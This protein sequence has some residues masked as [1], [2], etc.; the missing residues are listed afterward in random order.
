[1]ISF[2]DKRFSLLQTLLALVVVLLGTY[3]L[4]SLWKTKQYEAQM[5]STAISCNYDIKRLGGYQFVKPLMFVDE[6]CESESLMDTKQKLISIIDQYKSTGAIENASVYLREYNHNEW[7]TINEAEKFDPGSLFKVPIMITILK[8]NELNPGFLNKTVAYTHAFETGK[9]VEFPSKTITVG[10]SYTIKEL[11]T[12]MI[13]YSDNNAT[14]LLESNMDTKLMQKMFKDMNLEVPN[15]YAP[16]FKFTTKQYSYFMRA[17]YNAGYLTIDDSEFAGQLLSKCDF[18]QG[19]VQGIPAG[20]VIAHKF[21]ES[22]VP[23]LKQLHESGIVYLKNNPY[24]LT[25]MTRGKDNKQLSQLLGELSKAVYTDMA[26]Q[27]AMLN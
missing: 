11:L 9:K 8:M 24:L 25:I 20:T 23:N 27:A 22:G 21:G 18:K 1:M 2:K 3:Y 19:M 17:I 4:T 12:Y 26:S 10:K 5:S 6:D 7:I 16:E 15:I 14:T 13:A